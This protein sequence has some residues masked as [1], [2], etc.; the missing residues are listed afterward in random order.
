MGHTDG[1]LEQENHPDIGSRVD[2]RV[3]HLN[4]GLG[5]DVPGFSHWWTLVGTQEGMAHKLP[6]ASDSYTSAE[7]VCEEQNK[8]VSTVRL[9]NTSAVAYISNQGGTISKKPVYLT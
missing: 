7:N 6:G 2:H 1:M 9:D 8:S 3:R 5:S 4:L